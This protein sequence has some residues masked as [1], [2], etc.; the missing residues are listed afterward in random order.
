ML[1]CQFINNTFCRCPVCYA[2]VSTSQAR[3]DRVPQL[4]SPAVRIR[5]RPAI[6]RR[7]RWGDAIA[8]QCVPLSATGPPICPARNK[9]S[10]FGK[11]VMH[12]RPAVTGTARPGPPCKSPEV[13]PANVRRNFPLRV[14]LNPVSLGAPLLL[15]RTAWRANPGL[16]ETCPFVGEFPFPRRRISATWCPW[17][18]LILVP[19]LKCDRV[20]LYLVR[21]EQAQPGQ[22]GFPPP[23]FRRGRHNTVPAAAR[24][25]ICSPTLIICAAGGAGR[26]PYH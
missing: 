3:A 20:R 11:P 23:V 14:A 15:Q 6:P 18:W 12:A 25:S 13:G 17:P 7:T 8:F 1:C 5:F 4:T 19:A 21:V 10:A 22:S 2:A 26:G 24:D 9:V 16:S